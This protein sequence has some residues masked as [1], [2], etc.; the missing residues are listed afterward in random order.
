MVNNSFIGRSECST[1]CACA[2]YVYG[3]VDIYECQVE[4]Q[5]PRLGKLKVYIYMRIM[6]VFGET[7]LMTLHQ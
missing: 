1:L 6:R 7:A 4:K 2:M 5:F 3:K